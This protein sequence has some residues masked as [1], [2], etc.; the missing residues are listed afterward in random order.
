M[1][2]T[3]PPLQQVIL[4]TYNQIDYINKCLDSLVNS[5]QLPWRVSVFDDF[6]TDGTREVLLTYK[7]RFPN[8]FEL[9]FNE[10]NLGIFGNLSQVAQ[11]ANGDLIHNLAGDDWLDLDFF[12]EMSE[13]YL[14]NN[15]CTSDNFIIIP[16]FYYVD[17]SGQLIRAEKRSFPRKVSKQPFDDFLTNKIMHR[18][19]GMSREFYSFW[20]KIHASS[21]LWMDLYYYL[22]HFLHIKIVYFQPKAKQYYRLGSG[23]SS[24]SSYLKLYSS[25]LQANSLF[26]LDYEKELSFSQLFYIISR[27]LIHNFF[28]LVYIIS[29]HLSLRIYLA[30]LKRLYIK[31]CCVLASAKLF[32]LP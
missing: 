31:V 26:I 2:D 21:Q 16:S 23:I 4:L 10:S 32:F 27:L 7:N 30:R 14:A 18:Y 17:I 20:P 22:Q 19:C 3:P 13:Y 15:L 11:Y 12:K 25:F 24:R 5:S 1:P 29:Q 8:L 9:I 28:A 6:S